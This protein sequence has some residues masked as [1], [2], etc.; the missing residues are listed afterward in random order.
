[1]SNYVHLYRFI[2]KSSN[3]T[4][5]LKCLKNK[6][7]AC[8]CDRISGN[9]ISFA[10]DSARCLVLRN[11]ADLDFL[12]FL[13][14]SARNA[15]NASCRRHYFISKQNQSKKKTF[16]I[17]YFFFVCKIYVFFVFYWLI[18]FFFLYIHIKY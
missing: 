8:S 17:S 9:V 1:M 5:L 10:I 18:I 12:A 4:S 6:S 15:L 14:F 11:F 2:C 3:V 16:L 13:S 7:I